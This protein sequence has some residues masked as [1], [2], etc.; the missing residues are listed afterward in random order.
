MKQISKRVTRV[1]RSKDKANSS[2]NLL[3]GSKN[4]EH[5]HNGGNAPI[6]K[7]QERAEGSD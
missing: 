3:S 6:N 4:P 1:T 2:R 5:L 7:S